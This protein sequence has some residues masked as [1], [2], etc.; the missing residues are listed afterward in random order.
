VLSLLDEYGHLTK[1]EIGA[2][3]GFSGE[4]GFTSVP[5]NLFVHALCTASPEEQKK[6]RSNVEGDSDKYARMIC[7]LL[8]RSGWVK[9]ETKTV[10]EKLGAKEYTAK[11]GMSYIIT[12]EGR[13]Q[14]KA[15]QGQSSHKRIPKIVLWESL[16]T[17]PS[18][19]VYLRNRRAQ[20]IKYISGNK[21]ILAQIMTHLSSLGFSENKNT[22][23]DDIHNFTNIGLSVQS[24]GNTYKI[25]DAINFL[26]I[27]AIDKQSEKSNITIMKDSI[28]DKLKAVNHKY[29]SLIDLAFN[30]KTDRDFEIQTIALLVN[31]IGFDGCHLGGSRRPDGIIYKDT[32]GVIV[33]NK[34]YSEGFTLPIKEQDKMMRYIEDNQR[35]NAKITPNRWWLNFP[36]NVSAFSFLF[37]SSFFS[38]DVSA[39]IN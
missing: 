10:T 15:A 16:A 39:K 23:L 18:D 22:I 36:L 1:F 27:P 28:R 25:T 14:L 19:S 38:T 11:I 32:Q 12:L 4:A 17:K 31:E 9:R 20:I 3:L 35:R 6:I 37:V 13:R 7:G 30:N 34:A 5:Q 8:I 29:L 21:R 2:K 33:D 26:T 24:S